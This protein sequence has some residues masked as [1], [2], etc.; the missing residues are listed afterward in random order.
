MREKNNNNKYISFT[1]YS[2]DGQQSR[3]LQREIPYKWRSHL[4]FSWHLARMESEGNIHHALYQPL[5]GSKFITG[6]AEKRRCPPLS[7]FKSTST[8]SG[9]ERTGDER[10]TTT[11]KIIHGKVG[12]TQIV[13]LMLVAQKKLSIELILG[14]FLLR[15]LPCIWTLAKHRWVQQTMWLSAGLKRSSRVTVHQR[16]YIGTDITIES[17]NAAG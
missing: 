10:A 8:S 11:T 13:I 15:L 7:S 17:S 16:G 1:W 2:I 9:T 3:Q 5:I 6:V 14:G 4:D 12:A